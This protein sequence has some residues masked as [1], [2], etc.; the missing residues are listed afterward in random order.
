MHVYEMWDPLKFQANPVQILCNNISILY[1]CYALNLHSDIILK[2]LP[3]YS[4]SSCVW[5]LL[6]F[7]PSS[8]YSEMNLANK[9]YVEF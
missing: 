5:S 9:F 1:V 3:I 8:M 6:C 7:I 2:G 4:Q